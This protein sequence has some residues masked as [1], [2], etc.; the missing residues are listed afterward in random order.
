MVA[1]PLNEYL[2]SAW[3]GWVVVA[4]FLLLLLWA[5]LGCSGPRPQKGGKSTITTP[6]TTVNVSQPENPQTATTQNTATESDTITRIPLQTFASMM[7]LQPTNGTSLPPEIAGAL[8]VLAERTTNGVIEVV[9]H[10]KTTHAVALGSSWKDT[11]RETAAKLKAL[12]WLPFVGVALLLFGA[13]SAFWP[14][15]KLIVGSTTTSAACCAV[16]VGLIVLPSLVVGHE[17]LILGCGIGAVGLWWFA[18]Q[19][20]KL[21][22]LVDANKDGIDDRIQPPR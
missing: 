18:H 3:R 8:R 16:G 6:T 15:L 22:G 9:N 4:L 14:P 1:A 7:E 11:A 12:G 19:H 17:L 10:S 2:K 13:A 5:V 20:G 21:R